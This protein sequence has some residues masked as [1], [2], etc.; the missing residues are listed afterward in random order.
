[1]KS[2]HFDDLGLGAR[3]GR[4]KGGGPAAVAACA[5][6]ASIVLAAAG[7]VDGTGTARP[8]RYEAVLSAAGDGGGAALLAAVRASARRGLDT[9]VTRF[10]PAGR[11]IAATLV[12]DGREK[13]T[14]RAAAADAVASGMRL[15]ASGPVAPPSDAT[16][17][18]VL[19]TLAMPVRKP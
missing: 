10:V 7:P 13:T 6:F 5:A 4:V 2:R 9:R 18:R 17:R 8:V 19:R 3:P 16:I 15:V 14:V 12:I 1:M 11:A